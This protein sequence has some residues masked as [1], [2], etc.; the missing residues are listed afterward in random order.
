MSGQHSYCSLRESPR[1]ALERPNRTV[2]GSGSGG[3]RSRASRIRSDGAGRS[4]EGMRAAGTSVAASTPIRRLGRACPIV[5]A[6][7]CAWLRRRALP[8][9]ALKVTASTNGGPGSGSDV[10]APRHR[11]RC[12]TPGSGPSRP[13]P[14]PG[15][16]DRRA[17]TGSPTDSLVEVTSGHVAVRR[18]IDPKQRRRNQSRERRTDAPFLVPVDR[19]PPRS[20][21]ARWR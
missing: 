5:A 18:S 19:R 2:N 3:S 16:S 12:R 17:V 4:R 8:R 6:D 13:K 1:A 9:V 7:R 20:G 14:G 15:T 21:A 10:V 11:R